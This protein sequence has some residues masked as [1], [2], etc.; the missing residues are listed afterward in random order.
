[1]DDYQ[2]MVNAILEDMT[3]RVLSHETGA[4]ERAVTGWTNGAIPQNLKVRKKIIEL[5]KERFNA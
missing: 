1:M 2:K 4:S 5:Y 3:A